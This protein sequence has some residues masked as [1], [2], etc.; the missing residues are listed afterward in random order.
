VKCK[1]EALR[2]AMTGL[3][4]VYVCRIQANLKTYINIASRI[5][6]MRMALSL[7]SVAD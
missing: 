3:A 7:I 4:I 5:S 1:N 6:P 2:R